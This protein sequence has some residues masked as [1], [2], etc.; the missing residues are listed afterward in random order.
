MSEQTQMSWN[1]IKG[2]FFLSMVVV[3]WVLSAVLIRLIFKDPSTN[4]DKPLFLTYFSTAWFSL[5]L[6]PVLWRFT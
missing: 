1:K 6:V 5:Y 3:L 4:F 2:V